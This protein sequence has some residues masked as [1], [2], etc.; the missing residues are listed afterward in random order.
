MGS[1][2]DE[3]LGDDQA[4]DRGRGDETRVNIAMTAKILQFSQLKETRT[5]K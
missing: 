1:R 3:A 5:W 4:N 2:A